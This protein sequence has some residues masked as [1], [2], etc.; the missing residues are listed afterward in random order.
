MGETFPSSFI[1]RALIRLA[2]ILLVLAI[3][4]TT[5]DTVSILTF[6]AFA[7]GHV[8]MAFWYQKDAGKWNE[9]K[10]L[11]SLAV[12]LILAVICSM[13]PS[14]GFVLTSLA[15]ALHMA[16]DE[17]HL[18]GG[19]PSFRRLLEIAPFV[20]LWSSLALMIGYGWEV[21]AFAYITVALIIF[22]YG[23]FL[24]VRKQRP[25]GITFVLAFWA[26]AALGASLFIGSFGVMVASTVWF[27]GLATIHFLIWYG[28]YYLKVRNDPLKKTRYVRRTVITNAIAFFL[29]F[30]YG[31]G[32]TIPLAILF[33]AAFV[34]AWSLVHIGSSFRVSTFAGFV[35]LW[36]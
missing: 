21:S 32:L 33:S 14:T 27:F 6:F 8:V 16:V 12:V 1:V 22:G 10:V 4:F 26:I 9:A 11:V 30:L 25:D 13:W 28:D 2:S 5:S 17:L 20:T 7:M 36:R 29:A 24:S 35:K 31:Q 19:T 18:Y 23:V 15:F 34:N 3:V